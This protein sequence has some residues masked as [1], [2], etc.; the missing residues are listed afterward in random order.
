[1]RNSKIRN[2]EYHLKKLNLELPQ[3]SFLKPFTEGLLNG[4][5][6]LDETVE[7]NSS[8]ISL[9]EADVAN[10]IKKYNQNKKQY[11]LEI[12]NAVGKLIAYAE[13]NK[14]IRLAGQQKEYKTP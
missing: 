1:M 10:K 8:V 4:Y 9:M 2:L 7:I 13:K 11:Y 12:G 6:Y 14:I 5:S 3:G